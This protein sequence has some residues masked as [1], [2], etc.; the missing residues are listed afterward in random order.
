[1]KGIGSEMWHYRLFDAVSWNEPCYVTVVLGKKQRPPVRFLHSFIH[2]ASPSLSF[3]TA[4]GRSFV[5]QW[6]LV[7][8][9]NV[10]HLLAANV[11][12]K[13]DCSLKSSGVRTGSNLKETVLNQHF[14]EI[15]MLLAAVEQKKVVVEHSPSRLAIS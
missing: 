11:H 7:T 1:M 10:A 13:K 2:F 9:K 5:V 6:E 14:E 15:L 4:S 3:T 12:K 8:E